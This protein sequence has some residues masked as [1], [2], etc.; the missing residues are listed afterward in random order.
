MKAYDK[1]LDIIKDS[2]P[3]GHAERNIQNIKSLKKA[4]EEIKEMLR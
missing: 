2:K 3:Y 1:V 4:Q